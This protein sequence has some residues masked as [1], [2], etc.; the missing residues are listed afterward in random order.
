[1]TRC[2]ALSSE[3]TGAA[4]ATTETAASAS[5]QLHAS[6][7]RASDSRVLFMT[8]LPRQMRGDRASRGP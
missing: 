2:D 5:G 4:H 8:N 6:D 7:Q 1:M 3:P